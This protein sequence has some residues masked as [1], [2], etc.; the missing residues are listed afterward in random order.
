MKKRVLAISLGLV[1]MFSSVT[2][3]SANSYYANLNWYYPLQPEFVN[4]SSAYADPSRTDHIGFDIDGFGVTGGINNTYIYVAESGFVHTAFFVLNPHNYPD[5]T[6]Y[7]YMIAIESND[8]DLNGNYLIYNYQHMLSAARNPISQQ[9]YHGGE[10]VYRSRRIG[11]VGSTGNSSGPHLHMEITNDE[12]FVGN[13]FHDTVNPV[14]FYNT[15]I[16]FTGRNSIYATSPPVSISDT[17]DREVVDSIYYIDIK[18]IDHVG[19]ANFELWLKENHAKYRDDLTVVNFLDDFKISNEKC[20]QIMNQNQF[21][22]F[23]RYQ[24]TDYYDYEKIEMLR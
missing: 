23:A 17:L 1:I 14:L 15:R 6:G 4:I 7:G 8:R 16:I 18:L 13:N 10:A 21:S 9:L 2:S 22:M 5:H 11:R 24:A 3:V 12:G 19:E 20:K